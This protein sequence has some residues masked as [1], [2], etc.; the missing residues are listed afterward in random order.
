VKESIQFEVPLVPPSVN[1][2]V[3][4]TRRGIHYKTRA[5]GAF[6]DA[7]AICSRGQEVRKSKAYRVKVSVYLGFNQK[8][9]VDNFGKVVLDSLVRTR[10][11]KSD[12]AVT[13]LW[14]SKGRDA[15]NPRTEIT[16]TAL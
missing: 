10:V 9:D 8:G 2:Y 13:D 12:A 15:D 16:V 7:V 5:A 14:L 11:I 3:R 4:H 6:E 1:N